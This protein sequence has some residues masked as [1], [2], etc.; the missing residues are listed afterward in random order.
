M[1][2]LRKNIGVRVLIVLVIGNDMMAGNEQNNDSNSKSELKALYLMPGD[3]PIL[4]Q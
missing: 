2:I 4:L 1:D 3:L